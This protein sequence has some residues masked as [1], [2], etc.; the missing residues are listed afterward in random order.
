MRGLGLHKAFA[1]ESDLERMGLPRGLLKFA[2]GERSL[3]PAGR[4]EAQ[5][6]RGLG[7]VGFGG[8]GTSNSTRARGADD[9]GGGSCHER[10]R[11]CSGAPLMAN[12]REAAT[13]AAAAAA[14]LL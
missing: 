2:R 8:S 10:R 14:A 1:S 12:L 9:D 11:G 7:E 5:H 3:D 6:E 13:S 4:T